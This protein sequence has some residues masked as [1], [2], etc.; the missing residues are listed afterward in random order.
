[1]GSTGG[2]SGRPVRTGRA[3]TKTSVYRGVT[4]TSGASWGAKFA[5]KRICST[6]ATEE[7][8]ARL[9]DAHLK[10]VDPM[11]YK[12]YANFCPD[13]HLFRNTQRL[14]D[15]ERYAARSDHVILEYS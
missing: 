7:E 4:K 9:Y 3:A 10:E 11:K 15:V 6:C 5:S 1:M 8:A 2:A 14:V 12:L 13:C